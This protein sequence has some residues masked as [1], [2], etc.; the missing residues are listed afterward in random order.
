[1]NGA[2]LVLLVLAVPAIVV[3]HGWLAVR[4]ACRQ[5]ESDGEQR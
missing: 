5:L 2:L 1:M 3:I 4:A